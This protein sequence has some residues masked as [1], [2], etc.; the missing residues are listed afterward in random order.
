M[1]DEFG[2]VVVG[3]GPA[4]FSAARAYRDADGDGPVAIVTDEERMPYLRPPLTKELLRGDMDEEALPLESDAWLTGNDASLVGGRAMRID[5]VERSVTLAGGRSLGY[6]RCVLATGA[7][8]RRLPIP[9]VDD[10][11]VRVVRSLDHVRELLRRLV[12]GDPVI[13][14]GSGFIGCEIAASLRRRGHPVTMISDEQAPNVSRLGSES[15]EV[16]ASWLREEGVETHFARAVEAIERRDD[17]L[18]LSADDVPIE[19][20]VVVMA[21][22]VAPRSELVTA[23]GLSSVNGAVPVDVAMRTELPGV[24]AAGDVCLAKNATAGRRIRVEHWGDALEQGQ[25]AGATAA[26]GDARWDAVPGFWST[27]GDRVLKYAAWGDGYDV[28]RHTAHPDGG[29]TTWYGRQGVLVGVLAHAA[30][31]DYEHGG[32]LIARG[33]PWT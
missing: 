33:A 25:I 12:A 2:L 16:I 31:A 20:K 29:F 24:L 3:G 18:H 1:S 26:G 7:E 23:L 6:H 19:A 11:G 17:T 32:R 10:P 13:V 14:V 21:T 5:P 9:G 28:A 8:P 15:A 4:G 22:G 30:D 27:I